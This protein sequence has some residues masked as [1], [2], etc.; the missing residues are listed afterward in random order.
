MEKTKQIIAK[1]LPY[2]VPLLLFFGVA[3][4][5]FAPQFSGKVLPQHDVEQYEGMWS[6]I[7]SHREATGEDA[8]WTGG[9]FGGMPAYLINVK[10]PAQAVKNSIGAVVKVLDTPASFIFFA[11]TAFWLMM[12]IFGVSPWVGMVAALAYGLST[13]FFLIIGAGHVTKMWALVWAPLM[14]GG[15]YMTLRGKMLAGGVVTALFT[16]LELG[17]NH[18]QIT[19]YFLVA[20]VLFW[21]SELVVAIK[22]KSHASFW[23]R[24]VVLA[25]AGVVALGSNFAPL[26]YTSQHTKDTMRG[27]SELV[28]KESEGSKGLDLEYA[29]AWSYGIAESWNMLIPDFAGGDSGSS[30]ST[31]GA[32]GD[33]LSAVGLRQAAKQLPTYWGG[34]PYTAG[35]TYLG[36]VAIFLALLGAMLSRGRDRWWI[37]GSMVLMLLL[38]WGHNAMWFTELCFKYLPMYNKFRTVSTTLVVLEWAVPLFAGIALWKLWQSTDADRRNILRP[39]AWAAG[40][41]GG[42]CLLFAVAGGSLFDFGRTESEDLMIE[43]FYYMLKESG[44]DDYI[45]RGYHEQLGVDV[46]SAMVKERVAK[47]S[48]DAWRSFLFIALAAGAVALYA[49]RKMG[50]KG[51]IAVMAVLV[52]ADMVPVNMR[53]LSHERFVAERHTKVQP[54]QADLQILEDKDLGYRVLNLTVSPFNDATTSRFHRS[55]GGYHGA[56]LARYQDLIE[57]YL[58]KGD[59]GVLDMMNTRYVIDSEGKVLRRESANGAAW[60]VEGM[61]YVNSPREEIDALGVTDLKR[62]AVVDFAQKP[63]IGAYAPIDFEGEIHL[64]EYA[65]NRLKYHYTASEEAVAVFSEIFYNK[66]WRAYVDGV[67]APYFRADYLLRAMR[68]PAGEHDVEWRFRAPQWSVVEG[69]TA[70]FSAVILFGVVALIFWAIRR[71]L[72]KDGE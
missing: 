33:S 72:R 40:I 45:A 38:S 12:L 8:Q 6:D 19:Y 48:H 50:R 25:F 2:M 70:A 52:L 55:V 17:A 24:T 9:M 35:P 11:M 65:P 43:Q 36:A 29:T 63:D 3:A 32:V 66:G 71:N 51:L 1:I 5:Y 21:I 13:Y 64:T 68:L 4:A 44:A 37:I 67:E 47:M 69:V 15:A 42:I 7:R 56:K 28:S 14:M 34:Q 22:Q 60:F 23:K 57:N 39:M 49:L 20:M 62:V 58:A 53:F 27:G 16:S 18:P 26:W 59:E 31:D 54:T 61:R 46:A 41:T 30:F 10:Y